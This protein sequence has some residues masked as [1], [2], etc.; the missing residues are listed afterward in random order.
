MQAFLLKL[1]AD[2]GWWPAFVAYGEGFSGATKLF[3]SGSI[4]ALFLF[5]VTL[6]YG[7]FPGTRPHIAKARKR[8]AVL[9]LV[10]V[11]F[12]GSF[13]S[14]AE[15]WHKRR[16][17]ESIVRARDDRID[18]LKQELQTQEGKTRDLAEQLVR[19]RALGPNS[20]ITQFQEQIGKMQGTID[21]LSAEIKRYQLLL[22][23]R[24]LS[25]SSKRRLVELLKPLAPRFA[26]IVMG[27]SG[28]DTETLHYAFVLKEILK[29]SGFIVDDLLRSIKQIGRDFTGVR[30]LVRSSSDISPPIAELRAKLSTIVG[31]IG[32]TEYQGLP[33]QVS[34][35]LLVGPRQ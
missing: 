17:A 13:L 5:F 33:A 1:F 6:L 35:M 11:V 23:P 4:V 18:A 24:D 27:V 32:V 7:L 29:E 2:D 9:S 25:D 12:V 28:G 14:F 10:I 15:E 31:D 21:S 20:N 3:I 16:V 19:L 22:Q 26:P 34:F 8:L 30:L